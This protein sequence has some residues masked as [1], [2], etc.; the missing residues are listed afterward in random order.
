MYLHCHPGVVNHRLFHHKVRPNRS[1]VRVEEFHVHVL[2]QQGCFAH[3]AAARQ[4]RAW[5]AAA[6]TGRRQACAA[7][8]PHFDDPRMMIFSMVFRDCACDIVCVFE[9]TH[10]LPVLEGALGTC[11]SA[12]LLA[13]ILHSIMHCHAL[14]VTAHRSI[15]RRIEWNV[16][17]RASYS[18]A[19]GAAR[20]EAAWDPAR[21]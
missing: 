3:A 1:L 12:R 14:A 7:A 8:R 13:S 19:R 10:A 11:L 18:R 17:N 5:S 20:G 15:D 9:L 21:T 2:M 6:G 16:A 4:Q